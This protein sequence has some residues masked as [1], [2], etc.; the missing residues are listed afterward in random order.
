MLAAQRREAILRSIQAL[1]AITIEALRE[2][3]AVSD[4]TIR[5]DLNVLEAA[6]YIERTHGGAVRR[7]ETMIEPRYAAKQA[8][9]ASSKAAIAHY[10]A[11][12][13]VDD[14]DIIILEGGTTVTTMARY[15]VGKQNVTTITNGLYTTNELR[16]LMPHAAVLC[17][18]GLLRDGS[19]TFVGQSAEQFFGQFH[20]KRLFLSATGMTLA[21]GCTDPSEI[22]TQ[23]K[24]AMVAAVSQV[25]V[26]LDSS[27]IGVTS[28]LTVLPVEQIDILVT[29]QGAPAA[30]VQELRSR[31]V[32][33][34]IAA[35]VDWAAG[36]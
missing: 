20:A 24:K 2:K 11:T 31:G 14:G 34:R 30:F 36:D 10:A 17:T 21:A 7:S 5:R 6:G 19:F 3:Y 26:L 33:V 12:Q 16:R 23:V 4:M 27:K 25:I 32:D 9:N 29:D 18:G 15:L 8:L 35:D 1:G 22:E 28:L 13:L